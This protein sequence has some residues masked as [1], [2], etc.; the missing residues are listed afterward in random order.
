VISEIECGRRLPTVRTFERLRRGLGLEAPAHIL[1]RPVEPAE[2]P[3]RDL[4]RLAACLWACGG[5]IAIS[6]L[7]AALA[8]PAGPVREQLARVAPRLAACG[9]ALTEDTVEVRLAALA[10]AQPALQALGRITSERRGAALSDEAVA[11]LGYIGWH[12]EATRRQLEERRGESCETLLGRLVDAGFLTVVRDSQ[13]DG[14]G[15]N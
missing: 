9:I 15:R 12:R 6:E 3:E 14:A 11:I 4:V 8:L 7:A 13:G 2:A 10:A 5:H 1:T